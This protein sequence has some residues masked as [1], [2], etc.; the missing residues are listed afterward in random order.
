MQRSG[1]NIPDRENG[2]DKGA[3]VR[4]SL[5]RARTRGGVGGTGWRGKGEERQKSEG[6]TEPGGG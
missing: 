4:M 2:K 6:G 5:V 3:N 1:R